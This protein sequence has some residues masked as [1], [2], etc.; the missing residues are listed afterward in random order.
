[1]AFLEA[2]P[3][4]YFACLILHRSDVTGTP[5]HCSKAGWMSGYVKGDLLLAVDLWMVGW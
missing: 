5:A 1:M 3:P 4:A 2:L